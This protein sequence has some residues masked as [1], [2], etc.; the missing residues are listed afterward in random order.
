MEVV[1]IDYCRTL[2]GSLRLLILTNGLRESG[3]TKRLVIGAFSGHAIL[4]ESSLI[5]AGGKVLG[6]VHVS[7][8]KGAKIIRL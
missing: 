7:R 5:G 6:G 3:G 8:Q 1:S 2:Q 4:Q